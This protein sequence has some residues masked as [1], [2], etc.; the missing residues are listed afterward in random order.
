MVMN[1]GIYCV[2]EVVKLSDQHLNLFGHNVTIYIRSGYDFNI[3][4]GTII[5]D[6]P[7]DGPYAG[8]LFIV[9][10]DF[11]GQVPNCIINGDS[12]NT[13][14]GT[15]FAPYCDITINGGNQTTSYTAQ[16]IGYTV[17][18]LGNADTDLYYDINQSAQSDPKLGLMR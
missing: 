8:Y 6:A 18:I 4:Q 11:T 1:P 3:Q 16:V 12:S 14:T 13:Y 10:S 9:D 17:T 7:D 15:I 2:N 5:L